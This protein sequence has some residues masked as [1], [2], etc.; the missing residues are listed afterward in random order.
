LFEELLRTFHVQLTTGIRSNMKN[1]L[2]PLMDKL[3]LG[4]RAI[5][6][7]IIEQLKNISQ[8]EH[9]RH[10]RPINFLVNLSCGLI[11]YCCQ[12]KNPSLSIYLGT[13]P[14]LIA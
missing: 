11:A 6:E 13:L 4:K 12:P 10:S 3:L 1:Q 8:M 5:V 14:A 9:S 7:T 2:M